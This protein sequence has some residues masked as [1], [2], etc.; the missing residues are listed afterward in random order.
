MYSI[1]ENEAFLALRKDDLS[2]ATAELEIEQLHYLQIT[3]NYKDL[4]SL[5]NAEISSGEQAINVIENGNFSQYIY[6]RLNN[7]EGS[8]SSH[9]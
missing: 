8:E 2:K 1:S 6:D 3:E 9:F 4:E 5:I 7:V